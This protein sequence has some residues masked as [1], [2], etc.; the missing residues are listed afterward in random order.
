MLLYDLVW[1]PGHSIDVGDFPFESELFQSM[2]ES[3]EEELVHGV[4]G[5]LP[6]CRMGTLVTVDGH[7]LLVG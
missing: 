5:H 1:G 3:V 4:L 6:P 7:H 2:L